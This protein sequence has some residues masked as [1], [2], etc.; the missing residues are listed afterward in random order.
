MS[1]L[2]VCL[3]A[4]LS[5]PQTQMQAP[6]AAQANNT[7]TAMLVS[8]IEQEANGLDSDVSKLRIE[9]WK[10]DSNSKQQAIDDARSIQRNIS[11][12]LPD[13][14]TAARNNPQSLAANF[15]LY[16]NVNALYEV[17]SRLA[18]SAGAFGK[19][20]EY[21]AVAAHLSALDD[22]RRTF[23]DSLQQLSANAD[24]RSA[25]AAREAAQAAAQPP[26]KT[27]VDDAEP[28]PKPVS[29]KKHSSK[30]PA[31]AAPPTATGAATP[32]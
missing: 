28:A 18:E 14:L 1:I 27:I 26:K 6:P 7:E 5:F 25:A 22:V 20:E 16:R 32:Q 21:D 30:K 31:T 8:R 15:K 13:L 11:S 23:G 9:K 17:L 3:L 19:R 24:A 29:K 10:A 2:F 12:A 4:S